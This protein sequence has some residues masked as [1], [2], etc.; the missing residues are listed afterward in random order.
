MR[1][2][3]RISRAHLLHTL[4]A[5][6]KEIGRSKTGEPHDTLLLIKLRKRAFILRSIARSQQ[7]GSAVGAARDLHSIDISIL[8]LIKFG[9]GIRKSAKRRE[10][11]STVP[12]A[13]PCLSLPTHA[14][15]PNLPSR[16]PILIN[17]H[18]L[19]RCKMLAPPVHMPRSRCRLSPLV[20]TWK[21]PQ[22]S[23]SPAPDPDKRK[24]N[25]E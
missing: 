8:R 1:Y 14:A 6:G 15:L 21:S 10:K 24:R 5:S 22:V 18:S 3:L 2:A 13:N 17:G 25:G 9:G 11:I 20:G 16:R 12:I 7:L 19:S 23:N 4:R